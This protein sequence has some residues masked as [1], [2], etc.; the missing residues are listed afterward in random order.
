M[1]GLSEINILMMVSAGRLETSGNQLKFDIVIAK[2]V[3]RLGRNTVENL[4]T[5]HAIEY[6]D[7]RLILP[8]DNNGTLGTEVDIHMLDLAE[9]TGLDHVLNDIDPFVETIDDADH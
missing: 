6:M 5:V 2:S 1:V 3:S 8:E 9:I 4:Q 7:I